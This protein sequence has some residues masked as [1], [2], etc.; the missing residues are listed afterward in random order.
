MIVVDTSLLVYLLLPGEQSAQA[1]AVLQEDPRW[2]APLLWR[3]EFR[4]VL[5]LYLR[6]GKIGLAEAEALAG[7]AEV[8][9]MGAEFPVESRR[10]LAL[11][12][13]SGCTAYDCEFVALAM[14][15]GVPLVTTDSQLL[16]EFPA[17]AVSPARFAA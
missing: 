1:R 2:A 6:R 8:R 7:Q 17:V 14:D 11:A 10:V 12:A 4:N 5:L 3:S 9:M 15:L 16:K 13:S